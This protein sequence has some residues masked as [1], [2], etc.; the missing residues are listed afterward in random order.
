MSYHYIGSELELFASAANWK[1]Y[2]GVVLRRFVVGR[3]LEV[4]A[5]IGSNVSYLHNDR[6][7]EWTCLEPDPDLAARIEERLASG[8]LPANC[9]AVTGTTA[10]IDGSMLFDT[11][12]YL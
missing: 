9:R 8:Q 2:L 12:L 3:V 11:I 5:S 10:S 4:G 7:C 1:T 6:V